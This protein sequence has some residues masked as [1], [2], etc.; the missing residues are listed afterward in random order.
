MSAFPPPIPTAMAT[1]AFHPPPILDTVP[2]PSVP[3]ASS[4]LPMLDLVATHP[5]PAAVTTT[6]IPVTTT[7][8][9]PAATAVAPSAPGLIT[10]PAAVLSLDPAFMPLEHSLPSLPSVAATP[11]PNTAAAALGAAGK[12]PL[13]L[14]AF[15]F[16]TPQV[17]RGKKGQSGARRAV[18]RLVLVGLLGAGSYFGYTEGP[19]LYDQYVTKS[20]DTA[21]GEADAPLSLPT[22]PAVPI[23]VRTAEFMLSGLT[24]SPDT[25]YAVSIDFE[26]NVS[27]V[28]VTRGQGPDLEVLTLGD[29]AVVHRVGDAQWYQVER[30]TFPLDDQLERADWVRTLDELLPSDQ[31]GSVVI[32]RST[33]SVIAD[34]PARHL[35]LTVDPAI[36]AGANIPIPTLDPATGLPM[37]QPL[38]ADPLTTAPPTAVGAAAGPVGTI[39]IEIWVDSNGLVRQISGA[40][41]L[42]AE[43]ITVLSTS[44]Q[45][46]VPTFPSQEQVLPLTASALVDLGM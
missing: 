32:D 20:G 45:A 9:T 21:A 14:E 12:S 38:L 44:D 22:S 35:L 26:T 42:G 2:S 16:S 24:D 46:F 27:Q 3:L 39:Q 33:E 18:S 29:A 5:A 28:I 1:V 17:A 37:P 10:G 23:Q 31:R 19:A 43:M 8:P 34:V 6:E 13:S 25:E 30:G 4:P 41:Q 15:D 11:P 40:P 36:L 7:T